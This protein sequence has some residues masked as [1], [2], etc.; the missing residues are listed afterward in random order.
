MWYR[1]KR[2]VEKNHTG[3]RHKSSVYV[4]VPSFPFFSTYGG[5]PPTVPV[6]IPEDFYSLKEFLR[7][8]L[9]LLNYWSSSVQV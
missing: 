4:I 3:T 1:R 9:L 6:L 2:E 7:I 8:E 5:S